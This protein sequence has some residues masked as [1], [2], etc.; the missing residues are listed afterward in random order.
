MVVQW[1]LPDNGV[2][3]ATGMSDGGGLAGPYKMGQRN[4]KARA[5]KGSAGPYKMG[6]RNIRGCAYMSNRMMMVKCAES[7]P[8]AGGSQYTGLGVW[9]GG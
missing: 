5:Y 8:R 9:H 4:I 7:P 3:Y 2:W 1:C 6:Q